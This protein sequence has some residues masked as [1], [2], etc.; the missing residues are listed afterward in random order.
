MLARSEQG[1]IGQSE[2]LDELMAKILKQEMKEGIIMKIQDDVIIGGD[3][4]IQKA[5]NY[6]RILNKL[7]LTNL[8]V[9]PQKV[10][11]FPKSADIAGWIWKTG[12]MFSVSPHRKNIP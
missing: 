12:G 1:L 5:R 9:E 4:Q 2:E 10:V 3:T 7:D 8:R 11:I 6:I